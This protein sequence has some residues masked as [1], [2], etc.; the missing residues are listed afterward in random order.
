[1]E[2][3]DKGRIRMQ[4]VTYKDPFKINTNKELWNILQQY[5][6][7]CASDTLAQGLA[8]QYDRCSFQY[9]RS[10]E[11]V[12]KF[13]YSGWMN[14]PIGD[15]NIYLQ[16][17]SAISTE[18]DNEKERRV[19]KNNIAHVV[20]AIKFLLILGVDETEFPDRIN[21]DQKTLL[22]LY[23][24]LRD[25]NTFKH[26]YPIVRLKKEDLQRALTLGV[27]EEILRE[28]DKLD[29]VTKYRSENELIKM[30]QEALN[31]RISDLE[32]QHKKGL[33]KNRS[34]V[35]GSINKLKHL[36]NLMNQDLLKDKKII[37]HGIHR[38]TP[39]M[40]FFFEQLEKQ[41]NIEPIFVF[42]Y[43]EEYPHIY[44]TWKQVYS[45]TNKEMQHVGMETEEISTIGK[46]L[47]AII[48][49]EE[50]NEEL[51]EELHTFMNLTNFSNAI[52]TV[53]DEA[54]Q[55]VGGD[56]NKAL[57]E[58]K[59]Q[60]YATDPN[61][62]NNILKMYYPEQFGERQ[63]LAYPIGQFILALY[64]MWNFE[65]KEIQ[66]KDNA[67]EECINSGVF[68][69][70]QYQEVMSTYEK[71]KVYFA[72]ITD[73]PKSDIT[74]YLERIDYLSKQV[75]KI[76]KDKILEGFSFF[77]VTKEEL[78]RFKKYIL[79]L[80]EVSDTLF[81]DMDP[82]MQYDEHFKKLIKVIEKCSQDNHLVSDIEKE[83]ITNINKKLEQVTVER[84][85][86]L[87]E[88]IKEA[89]F[90]YLSQQKQQPS[91]HWIVRGFEQLDGAVLLS[92][93]SKAQ[94]YH[95]GLVSEKNMSVK[96]KEELSWPL[97]ESFLENYEGTKKAVNVVLTSLRERRNFMRYSLFYILA[98]SKKPIE[99]GYILE[100]DDEVNTPYFLL[101]LL[102]L[103]EP[104]AGETID[105]NIPVN[106][107]D[108]HIHIKELTKNITKE[109]K[110]IFAICPYKFFLTSGIHAPLIYRDEFQMRYALT[111]YIQINIK[112][113]VYSKE[114][115]QGIK[116]HIK[117]LFP[118]WDEVI[119]NDCIQKAL[120]QK[121]NHQKAGK[122]FITRKRNFLVN[123]WVD[124]ITSERYMDFSFDEKEFNE[125][126]DSLKV[127]MEDEH[128]PYT[129]VCECC[130]L[131]NLCLM[132]YYWNQG[133][134]EDI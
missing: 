1:M 52:A 20:E 88:D 31:Q 39:M 62:S 55:K 124:Q 106:S 97:T 105:L 53:Y 131:E 63:F 49:G 104:E 79:E 14:N 11:Y 42:N 70:D 33:I 4:V 61:K 128:I 110:D 68:L 96:T 114:D 67:L 40:Y 115:I 100:E 111:N 45:W 73:N 126:M 16:L 69:K 95:I 13:L 48:E 72:D 94:K 127:T 58:M 99:L 89:V 108:Q 56:I 78:K 120:S 129:K 7:L 29:Y 91:S 36:N 123:T 75:D 84:V 81:Q 125:Y 30:T 118:F 101:E 47:G 32:Q 3:Y 107:E 44:N 102:G 121:K 46:K 113:Q 25:N 28:I 15:M 64:N 92:Q 80:R 87:R 133:I 59:I 77:N 23:K 93:K 57:S 9:L 35:H 12:F 86:G 116:T 119:L 2:E 51:E 85:E 24:K 90:L 21:K 98:F 41:M 117:E 83:L 34:K 132:N 71:I 8:R 112:N 82:K 109:G 27:V 103:K 65:L 22:K 26:F 76:K 122:E 60:Y 6:Q 74:Y 19:F 18:L 130:N 54:Y 50:C 38:I 10:I 17:S 134:I 66:I 43:C 5:P 37:I